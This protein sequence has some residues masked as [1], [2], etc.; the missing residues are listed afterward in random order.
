M[1]VVGYMRNTLKWCH[2]KILCW[3]LNIEILTKGLHIEIQRWNSKLSKVWVLSAT[4]WPSCKWIPCQSGW[5]ASECHIVLLSA[6][7][8]HNWRAILKLPRLRMEFELMNCSF[9]VCYSKT[10]M[11]QG[12]WVLL[13]EVNSIFS[14][15]KWYCKN[16]LIIHRVIICK[17][18]SR[19]VVKYL[20]WTTWYKLS[21]WLK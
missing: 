9:F 5:A 6:L 12:H 14:W 2:K 16:F 11:Y 4:A 15:I 21:L 17:R 3:N 13:L 19:N 1:Q 10:C 18:D 20:Y 8:L 7:G